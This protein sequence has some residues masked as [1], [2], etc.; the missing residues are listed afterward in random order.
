MKSASPAPDVTTDE[1]SPFARERLAG[2]RESMLDEPI[3]LFGAGA[4]GS[5]LATQL[6]MWGFSRATVVDPDTYEMSNATRVVDFP[7]RRV[8]SGEAVAKAHHVAGR[9]RERLA[10]ADPSGRPSIEGAQCW[11]QELPGDRW[12][13]VVLAAVDHPRARM[14]A[15]RTA[16]RYGLPTIMGGFD[17]RSMEVSVDVFPARREAGCYRCLTGS[18]PGY[19]ASSLSCTAEA[20]RAIEARKLPATP[21]LAGA[22]AALMVQRLVDALTHG[23]GE[24]TRTTQWP[25]GEGRGAGAHAVVS[26]DP[27]CPFHDDRGEAVVVKVRGESLGDVL[28]A[29]EAA[30]PGALMG[31]PGRLPV[32][33]AGE[34]GGALLRVARPPWRCPTR[35]VEGEFERAAESESS[36]A[37]DAI[38]LAMATRHGLLEMPAAWFGWTVGARVE[39]VD[40][41]DRARVVVMRPTGKLMR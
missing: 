34:D 40:G 30:M 4:L 9:W 29:V 15:V 41:D 39:V 38:D 16:R 21:A 19:A 31:L 10:D 3:V 18:E 22:C 8:R 35:I 12:S 33:V 6:S 32:Y 13:G 2:Y 7:Y 26:R 14:D 11:L 5:A 23:W 17:G 36:L 24:D 37:V 28:R 1:H 27:E 25:L 20:L